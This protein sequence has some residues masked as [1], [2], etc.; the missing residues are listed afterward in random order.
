[1][2]TTPYSASP[3]AS[4][5][6]TVNTRATDQA[7][8]SGVAQME[9]STSTKFAGAVW[10]PYAASAKWAYDTHQKV[11][12]YYRFMDGAGNVS[13]RYS[14]TLSNPATASVP[15]QVAPLNA[16]AT[17][18]RRPAFSW[19]ALSGSPSYQLQVSAS[20]NFTTTLLN[21][22]TKKPSV[23][24]TTSLPAGK[25]YWRV[26]K[27]GGKWSP[28]WTFTVPASDPPA[29]T[30]P[31]NAAAL[32]TL[33]PNLTWAA[34]SGAGSYQLQ[35]GP[36]LNF[37]TGVQT[38]GTSNTHLQLVPL[39]REASYSWRVRANVN[40]VFGPWSGGRSFTTPAIGQV[41]L[42]LP[43]NGASVSLPATLD[44]TDVTGAASYHLQVCSN[45]SCSTTVRDTSLA[46]SLYQLTLP[47]PAGTY[48]WRVQAIGSVSGAWSS[49]RSFVR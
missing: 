12:V 34:V 46:N 28:A 11:T 23:R 1:M 48:Y 14:K 36:D 33:S 32:G 6:S 31:I 29:L 7:G 2:L 26:R 49:V 42:L 10:Q 3:A 38:F 8:G 15:T 22:T 18:S 17:I 27:A 9:L 30:S 40:G 19:L 25:L 13:T 16:L 41:T 47:L 21:T 37:L 43:G 45:S 20:S 24:P 44:W 5:T 4:R 39:A 35:L